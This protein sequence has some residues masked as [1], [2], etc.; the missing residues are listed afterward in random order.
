[1]SD[2][3]KLLPDNIANQIA[4]GEVV[5]RPASVV[6]ELVENSIDSGANKIQIVIKDAGRTLIQVID[7]GCG[8]SRNDA[9]QCFERHAT[10]K[11]QTVD[12]LFSLTTKGFRGEALA[13]I[14]SI[15]HVTLKTKQKDHELGTKVEI[16]GNKLLG[17]E[18]CTCSNGTSIEVKNLFFNVPA[19]RNF[20]KSD[21]VEFNHILDEFERISLAHSDL[22][23]EL[24]HNNQEIFQLHPGILRK[25]IIEII[26]KQANDKLVPIEEQTAIV[27]IAGYIGKPEFAKKNRG[28]QFLFV[29]NRYFKDNY[30]QHA[31]MKGYDGMLTPK[32]FPS[33]FIFLTVDPKKI[34]VNVHPTKTEIKFEE[35]RSIYAIIMSSVR[36]ALGKYNISPTLDFDREGTFDLPLEMKNSPIVEPKISV[37]P[38]YNPF[39]SN[40]TKDQNGSKTTSV[41]GSA[42][43]AQGF[44]NKNISPE[45]WKD[46][47]QIKEFEDEP[48]QA[49]IELEI[50]EKR[51]YLIKDNYLFASI[52]SGLMIIHLK[53][54]KERIIYDK[55]M[56]QFVSEPIHSQQLLFP[57]EKSLSNKEKN[58]WQMNEALF[59]RLGFFGNL[60]NEGLAIVAVPSILAENTIMDCV[61]HLFSEL[62]HQEIDKGELAHFI[63]VHI[64]ASASISLS[65]EAKGFAD[66]IIEQ[67][68]QCAE[69]IYSPRGKKILETLSIEMLTSNF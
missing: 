68:F 52:K 28:E 51:D 6:K 9:L 44:G 7:N 1:M 41:K 34:D 18:P 42:L 23:F 55:L 21:S 47:Y 59:N 24:H 22:Q 19:R 56:S 3:I 39:S 53:R 15:A 43:N 4:A 31:L 30:F 64:S 45:D 38:N 16:E 48:H 8:M 10:S 13:S 37:N 33:Y 50:P 14:A 66:S 65:T 58:A 32:M 12:D 36:Q 40:L 67:L 69:H 29:N 27:S 20:L 2:I 54:A 62:D 17:N 26:G 61:D 57:I 25:R 5:Q 49:T 46:F 60:K 35:D 11:V 63:A